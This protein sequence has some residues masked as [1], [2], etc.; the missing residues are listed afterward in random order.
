MFL[1]PLF[2]SEV[3]WTYATTTRG[4]IIER[5]VGRN[6]ARMEHGVEEDQEHDGDATL[7][8]GLD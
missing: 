4:I 3:L 5:Y 8:H 6:D 2:T 1:F 7:R